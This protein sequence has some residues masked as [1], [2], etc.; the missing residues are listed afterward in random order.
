[1]LKFS[2]E[3]DSSLSCGSTSFAGTL[4]GIGVDLYKKRKS[5]L[6]KIVYS[7]KAYAIQCTYYS[8]VRIIRIDSGPCI[9]ARSFGWMVF[10]KNSLK[11]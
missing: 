5:G 4:G 9:G 6:I 1:M 8:V 11:N 7:V 10:V 2:N 3:L